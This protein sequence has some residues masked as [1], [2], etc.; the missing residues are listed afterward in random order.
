MSCV[1]TA[2]PI[3]LQFGMLSRMGGENILHG[4]IDIPMGGGTFGVSGP[5][6]SIGFELGK[7]VSC[8]KNGWTLLGR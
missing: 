8:T 2:E 6:K 5:L 7:R 1:K 3:K 4:D